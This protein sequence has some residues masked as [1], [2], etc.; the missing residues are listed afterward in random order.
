MNVSGINAF[1]LRSSNFVREAEGAGWIRPDA[2]SG[3]TL[4]ASHC[5]RG[6]NRTFPSAISRTPGGV[7]LL[8]GL[9]SRSEP[10]TSVSFPKSEPVFA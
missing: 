6:P 7:L 2:L 8:D 4:R 9:P 10:S 1:V 5:I 3:L